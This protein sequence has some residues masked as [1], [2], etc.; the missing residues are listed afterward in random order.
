MLRGGVAKI[1]LECTRETLLVVKSAE[2]CDLTDP[3]LRVVQKIGCLFQPQAEIV[4]RGRL[5][6]VSLEQPIQVPGFRPDT[7][8]D[9]RNRQWG[10]QR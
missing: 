5:F 1:S 3:Q 9:L 2:A 8:S 4:A 6:E 7:T 10:T